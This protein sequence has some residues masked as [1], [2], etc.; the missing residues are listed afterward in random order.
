MR[1]RGIIKFSSCP[2]PRQNRRVLEIDDDRCFC[3]IPLAFDDENNFISGVAVDYGATCGTMLNPSDGGA[4]DLPLGPTIIL[5]TADGRI[6]CFRLA[7]LTDPPGYKIE[8]VAREEPV[9][10]HTLAVS[11]NKEDKKEKKK[12]KKKLQHRL[13]TFGVPISWQKTRR[14]KRK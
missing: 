7:C 5:S 2:Q 12:R 14:I 3:T 10:I 1:A 6:A 11:Q 9:K 13:K 8:K 4:G